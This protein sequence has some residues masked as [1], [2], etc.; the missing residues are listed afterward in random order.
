MF[1]NDNYFLNSINQIRQET[2]L[3]RAPVQ[4]AVASNISN[5]YRF[6]YQQEFPNFNEDEYQKFWMGNVGEP[7]SVERDFALRKRNELRQRVQ[8]TPVPASFG[9]SGIFESEQGKTYMAR[10]LLRAEDISRFMPYRRGIEA[11][12]QARTIGDVEN[13]LATSMLPSSFGYI[14]SKAGGQKLD[15][16]YISEA[17]NSAFEGVSSILPRFK[18]TYGEQNK[19]SQFMP[20]ATRAG[21]AGGVTRWDRAGTGSSGRGL[22]LGLDAMPQD[23]IPAPETME[24]V[25]IDPN[26]IMYS[27]PGSERATIPGLY[28]TTGTPWPKPRGNYPPA[29]NAPVQLYTEQRRGLKPVTVHP[30]EYEHVNN[31]LRRNPD[32]P[33]VQRL[34]HVIQ[35]SRAALSHQRGV[36]SA[37]MDW[38]VIRQAQRKSMQADRQGR[39]LAVTPFKL[40]YT[41][42]DAS[43]PPRSKQMILSETE[44]REAWLAANDQDNPDEVWNN[45]VGTMKSS[46]IDTNR[47]RQD[48]ND[49]VKEL[50]AARRSRGH[51]SDVMMEPGAAEFDQTT[52]GD[53]KL[54]NEPI[55]MA[56]NIPF[57]GKRL[58]LDER[59]FGILLNRESSRINSI[60]AEGILKHYSSKGLDKEVADDVKRQF[61]ELGVGEG[62]L[63]EMMG[64]GWETTAGRQALLR[65]VDNNADLYQTLLDDRKGEI[66]QIDPYAP[67]DS[68]RKRPSKQPDKQRTENDY[69]PNP[70]PITTA[71]ERAA[72]EE[73][74]TRAT[75]MLE[76][77]ASINPVQNIAGRQM[78]IEGN[79]DNYL[80]KAKQRG[81]Q[82]DPLVYSG[83]SNL[84]KSIL[85]KP[86]VAQP[87]TM[88][89]EELANLEAMMPPGMNSDVGGDW[90]ANVTPPWEEGP[91]AST[92][93]GGGSGGPPQPP[94]PPSPPDDE[95]PE[96]RRKAL[97]AKKLIQEK[98]PQYESRFMMKKNKEDIAAFKQFEADNPEFAAAFNDLRT[99][100]FGGKGTTQT[101][102]PD[103]QNE[104]FDH[105][106]VWKTWK[107]DVMAARKDKQGG[108]SAKAQAVIGKQDQL[109]ARMEEAV[110]RTG[111]AKQGRLA[112]FNTDKQT[113]YKRPGWQGVPNNELDSLDTY[114][115]Q[116]GITDPNAQIFELTRRSDLLVSHE[117]T[118][119]A[120]MH[121]SQG[122]KDAWASVAPGLRESGPA[123]T[124]KEYG[125]LTPEQIDKENFAM[126]GSTWRFNKGRYRDIVRQNFPQAASFFERYGNE[127]AFNK[128]FNVSN[129]GSGEVLAMATAGGGQQRA[130]RRG[131][132]DWA[133]SY[134][135]DPDRLGSIRDDRLGE[136]VRYDENGVPVP[137][138]ANDDRVA[139]R[140]FEKDGQVT[141]DPEGIS[142]AQAVATSA[143]GYA[144]GS[145]GLEGLSD[146][147]RLSSIS[148][149]AQGFISSFVKNTPIA[150]TNPA[151]AGN[152]QAVAKALIKSPIRA[153]AV[154]IGSNLQTGQ[155]MNVNDVMSKVWEESAHTVGMNDP[156]AV[157]DMMAQSPAL[158]QYITN[159]GGLEKVMNSPEVAF[160]MENDAT[161]KLGKS[162]YSFMGGGGFG[163]RGMTLDEAENQKQLDIAKTLAPKEF[164]EMVEHLARAGETLKDIRKDTSK[165]AEFT[166]K[167]YEAMSADQLGQ[168]RIDDLTRISGSSETELK[169]RIGQR[170][171]GQMTRE[172]YAITRDAE[173]GRAQEVFRR[174][175]EMYTHNISS[176]A[177]KFAQTDPGM[178]PLD[179]E[180][181]SPE[182]FDEMMKGVPGRVGRGNSMF[183]H[184]MSQAAYGMWIAQSTMSM[185]TEPVM[186]KV[187]QYGNYLANF[188]GLE[189]DA[190]S[191]TQSGFALRQETLNRYWERG[192][193]QQFGGLTDANL[194]LA[195]MDKTGMLPRAAAGVNWGVGLAAGGFFGAMSLSA[196][197]TAGVTAA[198]GGAA[199]AGAGLLGM[200]TPAAFALGGGI[201]AGTLGME[202][203]NAL[204]P[205]DQY[206]WGRIAS[207]VGRNAL[208]NQVMDDQG[209]DLN[210]SVFQKTMSS[211]T[212]NMRT[213]PSTK[214]P[215]VSIFAN[216]LAAVLGTPVTPN[217]DESKLTDIERMALE[218][219]GNYQDVMSQ[220][221]FAEGVRGLTGEDTGAI[222]G[223]MRTMRRYGIS[224]SQLT[225]V[226][227]QGWDAGQFGLAETTDL[228]FS[229]ASA[230]GISKS[231]NEFA[232]LYNRISGM[233]QGQRDELEISSAA[234]ARW[235]NTIAQYYADPRQANR[236][237]AG[238][239]IRT[240]ADAM[241]YM[242]S[243][244]SMAMYG[245][246]MG[247]A[248]SYQLGQGAG[249]A[250]QPNPMRPVSYSQMIQ[251]ATQKYGGRQVN[252][253]SGFAS[254]MFNFGYSN[255]NDAFTMGLGLNP[256]QQGVVGGGI[257][258]AQSFG[259]AFSNAEMN[260]ISAAYDSLTAAQY[261][262]FA[263]IEQS[264]YQ[265]G[266]GI[267]QVSGMAT[268][269]SGL[270]GAQQISI[271]SNW[272]KL[273]PVLG[274][275]LTPQGMGKV[276]SQIAAMDTNT[277]N[278]FTSASLGDLQAQSWF[279]HQNNIPGG[280]FYDQ[281]GRPIIQTSGAKFQGLFAANFDKISSGLEA[282]Q[283]AGMTER[284]P[285]A[286]EGAAEWAQRAYGFSEDYAQAFAE[287]GLLGVQAASM[288]KQAGLAGAGAAL[289]LQS[290]NLQREHL[291]GYGKGGSWDNP[292]QGSMWWY[293]DVQRQRGYQSQQATFASQEQ[294]MNLSQFFAEKNEN[295]QGTRM[296][297]GHAYQRWQ[298]GFQAQDMALQRSWTREDWQ[299]QEQMTSLQFSWQMEDVNEAI[300]TSS[301]RER[302]MNVRQRERMTTQHSLQEEQ[303]EKVQ[304]RQEQMWAREDE[305][306]QKQMQ[307]AE[308]LMALDEEAFEL[309][310]EQ[311]EVFAQLDKEDFERG[312]KEYEDNF[313]LQEEVTRKQR[314][315]QSKQMEIQ[316]KQI[317]LSAAMAAEQARLAQ[318]TALVSTD[319]TTIEGSAKKISEYDIAAA[320]SKMEDMGI[321]IEEVDK[322]SLEDIASGL[323]SLG[324]VNSASINTTLTLTRN[325]F[326][327][328]AGVN[329]T[330]LRQLA[331]LLRLM[332]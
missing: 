154:G 214:M 14:A 309:G 153:E 93:S 145:E 104:Y 263:G 72:R 315:Y 13:V 11:L 95:I 119:G 312:R 157:M 83:A 66:G 144:E 183:S 190:V 57:K 179:P 329:T 278:V 295:I 80:D 78:G 235:G 87:P 230:L 290:L 31:L 54:D 141:L 46:G 194:A 175:R 291:W 156:Q 323:H 89:D 322:K 42:P 188:Q 264:M 12:G 117:A 256:Y 169:K 220:Q 209:I 167:V 240:Y 6:V 249:V 218:T 165:T 200:L 253:A 303:T 325:L 17:I 202:A 172:E 289:Q 316:E 227:M 32:D 205:D 266:A 170:D 49:R 43:G 22:E 236:F 25:G 123:T 114:M 76:E 201:I 34:G 275:T 332:D 131:M 252:L 187:Q 192:A 40:H 52:F 140:Q 302:K 262:Q 7:N 122:A 139:Y 70:S 79:T 301:G 193:M 8:Q 19:R 231:S 161:I 103:E 255:F 279:A 91:I 129:M 159:R 68:K 283:L 90:E 198:S 146:I 128:A 99:D 246:D 184:P 296:E 118:H 293:E 82:D 56:L 113:I 208:M 45:Y 71:A 101:L 92:T 163:G 237:T 63:N 180:S 223:I 207:N 88:S 280:M 164:K 269:F 27:E 135:N 134:I 213:T 281:Q 305:R 158:T 265:Y 171:I 149:R 271:A 186:Q 155:A 239:N 196:L 313:R 326:S 50:S 258:T 29:Y 77:G 47:F 108:I 1:F 102:S 224:Q 38:E 324:N 173:L 250:G 100:I 94:A 111:D 286:G 162:A 257:G 120:E 216:T 307:N 81:V 85:P 4:N 215:G 67:M 297:L 304:N 2:P 219:S 30:E 210:Q 151:K 3:L 331:D 61:A 310:I 178:D 15:D 35:N 98:Y 238:A 270:S 282:G 18:P 150:K 59:D 217:I 273:A 320:I 86:E 168:S 58:T 311:R 189:G 254:Q 292:S 177:L 55:E 300:R 26:A 23:A 137:D 260:T 75:K 62:E 251:E 268:E 314:E 127:P 221:V 294:R 48:V 73:T 105:N 121:L 143:W 28:S 160:T 261:Q 228:T 241:P 37:P 138:F 39:N 191:S 21:V 136:I 199:G 5:M 147:D 69:D 274:Q 16:D 277:Q 248:Y 226:A 285:L 20:W 203:Y 176:K 107:R 106:S 243:G 33:G 115:Q 65:E 133:S 225:D 51:G 287:G 298:F 44:L 272:S 327:A 41:E 110:N 84:G 126:L 197:G 244:Q 242:Q 125:S 247:D 185:F 181:V 148:S 321:A 109:F 259:M 306:F 234:T 211:L 97:A 267:G 288:Q 152:I 232:G 74:A 132:D 233:D 174:E 328:I 318:A 124:H 166:G 142:Q 330:K 24:M 60:E 245:I 229:V 212:G 112:G 204:N 317:G 276:F 308:E 9:L 284:M 299:Y 195:A 206:S 10:E 182:Q 53:Y 36:E 64:Q 96:Y 222:T 319:F 130:Q 116:Q